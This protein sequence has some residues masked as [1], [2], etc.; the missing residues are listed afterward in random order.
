LSSQPRTLRAISIATL[1]GKSHAER[2]AHYRAK[3]PGLNWAGV[4][5]FD[6][7]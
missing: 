5:V 7:N 6:T 3:L 1:W 2:I 4:F